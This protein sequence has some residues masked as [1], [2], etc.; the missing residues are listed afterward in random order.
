MN[1]K[2]ISFAIVTAALMATAASTPANADLVL[3]IN[4]VVEATNTTNTSVSFSTDGTPVQAIN[5]FN[6]N[7]IFA[8]G[9]NSFLGNGEL[10]DVGSLN[11]AS[12]EGVTATSLQIVIKETNLTLPPPP[13]FLSSVLTGTF[14][15]ASVTRSL[16]A[17]ATNSGLETTL[18]GM[19]NTEDTV[20]TL[21]SFASSPF[22]LTE[23]IDISALG[24]GA[25]LS[26]DDRVSA[27]P[28]TSTWAMMILG[29]M[30]IGFLAYRRKGKPAFRLA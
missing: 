26:S 23:E 24:A 10:L 21:T 1:I 7:S 4:G 16:Y 5:G 8:F 13:A 6:V 12:L 28:E 19:A 14:T 25:N 29:F 18:L 22:S 3:S 9:V 27:V 2:T 30:G 11:L 17:D 20:K 15:N